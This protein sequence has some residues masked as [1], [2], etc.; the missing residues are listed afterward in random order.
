MKKRKYDKENLL[1]KVVTDKDTLQDVPCEVIVPKESNFPVYV[2]L[3]LKANQ[4]KLI[5]Q[6]TDI[7]ISGKQI[8]NYF[9]TCQ[10]E[11]AKL[12]HTRGDSKQIIR[13]EEVIEYKKRFEVWDLKYVLD[14]H[15]KETDKS[16][17]TYTFYFSP[18]IQNL[19]LG[20]I[21]TPDF[22]TGYAEKKLSF[23]KTIDIGLPDKTHLTLKTPE[24]IEY[25]LQKSKQSPIT[26]ER[27]LEYVNNI[28][29]VMSFAARRRLSCYKWSYWDVDDTETNNFIAVYPEPKDKNLKY[30][31]S[32]LLFYK[33][34][35][36]KTSCE[37]FLSNPYKEFISRAIHLLTPNKYIDID[38]E[39]IKLFTIIEILAKRCHSKGISKTLNGNFENLQKEYSFDLKDLWQMFD[40][41]NSLYKIRNKI[42][43]GELVENSDYPSIIVAKQHLRWSIERIITKILGIDLEKT[44]ISPKSLSNF[45]QFQNW[46]KS[47]DSLK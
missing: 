42:T 18:K 21:F 27:L 10:I 12:I 17:I 39:Y 46:Q 45:L 3:F 4:L 30:I 20:A 15:S 26:S 32:S 1:V 19:V 41:K 6:S 36:A 40:G 14:F 25:V 34:D 2:D 8:G 33:P 35:I 43:H 7:T 16:T 29:V 13:G 31:N 23:T 38:T 47:H 9:P 22:S 11:A 5:L 37:K 24:T 28:L 44:D